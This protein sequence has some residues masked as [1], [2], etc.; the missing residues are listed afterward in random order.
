MNLQWAGTLL[1]VAT[2]V[3]IGA[4][5]VLV[6]W[7]HARFGTRPAVPLLITG[8]LTLLI[9]LIAEDDLLSGLLGISAITFLWDGV[10]IYR[11]EKRV[12]KEKNRLGN[13]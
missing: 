5:H 6:R 9:S 2:F 4:G 1:G 12:K 7:L 13:T 11:Q 8:G 10:E 3:T